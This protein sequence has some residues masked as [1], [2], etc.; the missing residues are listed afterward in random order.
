[1]MVGFG[2]LGYI[3]KRYKYPVVAM[4]LGIVLGRLFEKEFMRAWR[5]GLDSPDLFFASTI[6]LVL[7]GLFIFTFVGP[8]VIRFVRRKLAAK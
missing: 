3:M 5:M 4:L 2:L 1:A 8:P 7:W 6:T